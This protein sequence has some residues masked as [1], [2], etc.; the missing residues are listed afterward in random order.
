MGGVHEGPMTMG[1]GD[2]PTVM[3]GMQICCDWF[4][5]VVVVVLVLIVHMFD[6][7]LFHSQGSS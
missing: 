5:F 2:M 4:F 1:P 7:I 3:N 6:N